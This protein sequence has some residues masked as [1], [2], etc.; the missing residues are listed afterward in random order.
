M[1]SVTRKMVRMALAGRAEAVKQITPASSFRTKE[2][3]PGVERR[4]IPMMR[5]MEGMK[6]KPV[7]RS[8]RRPLTPY[9]LTGVRPYTP[10][11]ANS[12]GGHA[13]SMPWSQ[14]QWLESR[15]NGHAH[16]S[17]LTKRTILTAPPR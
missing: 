11:T 14:R 2:N 4:K 13:R 5:V 16:P 17:S 6:R 15:S 3:L 1:R 9:A 12:N 7:S 8:S 10:L